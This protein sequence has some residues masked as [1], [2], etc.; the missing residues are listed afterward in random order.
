[1]KKIVRC[2]ENT[3]PEQQRHPNGGRRGSRRK[4]AATTES[5]EKKLPVEMLAEENSSTQTAVEVESRRRQSELDDNKNLRNLT[6]EIRYVLL[7]YQS[8]CFATS[9][10]S[11]SNDGQEPSARNGEIPY[12]ELDIQ[13]YVTSDRRMLDGRS[14]VKQSIKREF[15]KT[16]SRLRRGSSKSVHESQNDL[17]CSSVRGRGKVQM[18]FAMRLKDKPPT[19][20]G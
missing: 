16:L 6:M 12:D 20:G 10:C 3:V 18:D 2:R 11:R 9:P 19:N 17:T 15:L 8:R 5:S 4:Q 1:M 13:E 14:T 7:C